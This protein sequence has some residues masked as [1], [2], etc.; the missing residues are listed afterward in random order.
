MEPAAVLVSDN[1][2]EGSSPLAVRHS[3]KFTLLILS[4]S[5][6]PYEEIDALYVE[7]VNEDPKRPG[8]LGAGQVDLKS[9][10][11]EGHGEEWV[12]IVNQSGEMIGQAL[13]KLTFQVRIFQLVSTKNPY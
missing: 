1:H 9:V 12:T 3:P 8:I 7:I 10:F 4:N 11:E 13:V 2:F 6:I 5:D